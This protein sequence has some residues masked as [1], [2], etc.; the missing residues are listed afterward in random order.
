MSTTAGSSQPSATNF[1][2][3]PPEVRDMIYEHALVMHEPI[4]LSAIDR[5]R[6]PKGLPLSLNLLNIEASNAQVTN[7]ARQV[8]FGKNNFELSYFSVW[9]FW[10]RNLAC[11][12]SY[13]WCDWRFWMRN[14]TIDYFCDE[15][16][17]LES[18]LR[19]HHTS[20]PSSLFEACPALTVVTFKIMIT[21]GIAQCLLRT[22]GRIQGPRDGRINEVF[23]Y[24]IVG[25]EDQCQNVYVK[26]F[27][28]GTPAEGAKSVEELTSFI[29]KIRN[30]KLLDY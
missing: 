9:K 10:T 15:I 1:L 22:S 27:L 28:N 3:L 17:K 29:G 4:N 2:S 5:A 16:A 14:L 20:G 24:T 6:K 18:N 19:C 25:L 13:D 23:S 21:S 12:W 11:I 8:F 7:E 26:V 30:G